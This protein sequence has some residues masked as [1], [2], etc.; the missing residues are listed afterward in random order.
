MRKKEY[1]EHACEAKKRVK[2]RVGRNSKK[3]HPM[4]NTVTTEDPV[5]QEPE[6]VA[7]TFHP[8]D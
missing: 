3:V 1:S 6:S 4:F 7:G 8:H 2:W 5:F